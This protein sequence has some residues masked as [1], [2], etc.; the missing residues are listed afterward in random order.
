L[1]TTWDAW[2]GMRIHYVEPGVA[3][4]AAASAVRLDS[5]RDP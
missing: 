5:Y 1:G 3:E 4:A 2:Q